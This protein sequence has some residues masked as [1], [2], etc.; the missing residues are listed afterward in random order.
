MPLCSNQRYNHHVHHAKLDIIIIAN[1]YYSYNASYTA[2]NCNYYTYTYP[3]YFAVILVSLR[4]FRLFKA[5]L[6]RSLLL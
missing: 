5:S 4:W 1:Y 2:Y 3:I 6:S